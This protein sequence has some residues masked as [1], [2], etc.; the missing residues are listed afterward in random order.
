MS[1]PHINRFR[2]FTLIEL[3]VVVAII[4]LL[5]SILLPSLSRARETSRTVACM[6]I[7]RQYGVAN[8]MYANEQ[9]DW[10]VQ[11][12]SNSSFQ[13]PVGGFWGA[14]AIFRRQMGLTVGGSNNTPGQGET[15]VPGLICPS[16]NPT[17]VIDGGWW[18]RSF[19]FNGIA[20]TGWGKSF[21][22]A[23]DSAVFRSKVIN[24]SGKAM[25]MDFVHWDMGNSGQMR[26]STN[27]DIRGD[28]DNV[29]NKYAAFRH[30]EMTNML[31]YDGHG[32][33]R[34]KDDTW[35]SPESWRKTLYSVLNQ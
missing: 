8:Y 19:A 11:L 14:N 5:I 18:R 12:R 30:L 10:F 13:A 6:S 31:M 9:G 17:S 33:T 23:K 3:L 7:Q 32:E 21:D 26:A 1:H 16:K 25:G 27:W 35:R 24:P 15:T 22:Y 34:S 2:A 29:N 4:A 28:T 20:L